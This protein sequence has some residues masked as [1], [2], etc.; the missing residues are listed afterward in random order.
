MRL[1]ISKFRKQLKCNFY[2]N[3]IC[4]TNA[5]QSDQHACK[6]YECHSLLAA[7]DLHEVIKLN[8]A[9]WF[10]LVCLSLLD[11]RLQLLRRN[12]L[13]K[14][15]CNLLEILICYVVFLLREQNESLLK[16]L[17]AVTFRHL[18]R[19][20]VNE[21]VLING[22]NAFLIFVLV[23][24]L[25]VICQFR[26]E[27]FD[28]LLCRFKPE[29]AQSHSQVLQRDIVVHICVEELKCFFEILALLWSQLLSVLAS[30][31]LAD[32]CSSRIDIL[33]RQGHDLC[34]VILISCLGLLSFAKQKLSLESLS[35]D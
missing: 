12:I 6:H 16:L 11:H 25:S 22:Y 10:I 28:L 23:S 17:I 7:E 31:L 14:L 21:V 34:L 33:G 26:D 8:D 19:H 5:L 4:V 30:C 1:L 24:A 35:R 27:S 3:I 29:S 18:C 13:A 2:S 20:N 32:W 9:S 15:R